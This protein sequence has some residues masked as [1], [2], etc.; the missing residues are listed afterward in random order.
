MFSWKKRQHDESQ[1]ELQLLH[2]L[3]QLVI[4]IVSS[5]TSTIAWKNLV[6]SC[7]DHKICDH[8]NLMERC[9]KKVGKTYQN[10]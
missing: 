7:F 5:T 2:Q 6:Q 8:N 9:P 10:R 4:R 3:L 1:F